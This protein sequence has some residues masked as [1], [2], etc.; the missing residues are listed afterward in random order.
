[1]NILKPESYKK[2]DW[3]KCSFF[4]LFDGHGG[5]GCA[6]FLKERLHLYIVKDDFFPSN[7]KQAILN[8]FSRCEADFIE[9]YALGK[10]TSKAEVQSPVNGIEN[11]VVD[12]SGSCA[13]I[14]L[15][16]NELVYVANVGDSRAL[17]S[18]NNGKNIKELTTDHKPNL[19]SESKRIVA[20]KGKVYQ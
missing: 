9:F 18:E 10:A 12:R 19:I 15:F 5:E 4:G 13:L 7:P 3:P 2:T 6:N 8:G 1:M 11:K 20:N 17:L 14:V 16:V